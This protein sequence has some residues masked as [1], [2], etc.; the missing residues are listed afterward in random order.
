MKRRF[1]S[2]NSLA[3]RQCGV[4][5]HAISFHLMGATTAAPRET[6]EKLNSPSAIN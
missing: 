6:E 1:R 2:Y 3:T 5:L 4:S